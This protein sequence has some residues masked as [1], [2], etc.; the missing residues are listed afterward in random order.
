MKKF[1]DFIIIFLALL[2][3]MCVVASIG[4]SFYTL[5]YT[6][7]GCIAWLAIVF[8]IAGAIWIIYYFDHK[9]KD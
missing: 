5:Y 1:F 2:L 9:R 3:A 4:Y 7:P 6:L 8:P